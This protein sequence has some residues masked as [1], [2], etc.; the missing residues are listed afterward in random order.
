MK[1]RISILGIVFLTVIYC[2]VVGSIN[3][4][5]LYSTYSNNLSATHDYVISDLSVKLVS[6]TSQSEN[7]LNNCNNL[8]V[9]QCKDSFIHHF[10]KKYSDKIQK[11]RQNFSIPL[12]LVILLFKSRSIMHIDTIICAL[13]FL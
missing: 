13:H 10:P 5:I 9:S 4:S 8:P 6:H 7:L 2:F 12:F 11:N 3:S 1:N